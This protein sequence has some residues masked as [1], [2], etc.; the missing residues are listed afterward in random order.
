MTSLAAPPSAPEIKSSPSPGVPTGIMDWMRRKGW[1]GMRPIQAEALRAWRADDHDLLIIAGT[2]S[3]KTEAAWL[4]VA[5]TI[6]DA[7]DEGGVVALGLFPTKALLND[8]AGRLREMLGSADIPVH[9][10]HGDTSQA[11]RSLI[12]RHAGG[13]LLTTPESMEG[14]L[15]HRDNHR[16]LFGRVRAV[17]ID[18]YHMFLGKERGAHLRGLLARIER[19]QRARVR[20]V[21][22]SATLGNPPAAA[23]W[24]RTAQ[25]PATLVVAPRKPPTITC[26]LRTYVAVNAIDSKR[27]RGW[28]GSW[29]DHGD[30]ITGYPSVVMTNLN[31]PSHATLL[32]DL[33]NHH[34]GETTSI[35][36]A[37]SRNRIE[38]LAARLRIMA[39]K[40]GLPDDWALLHH[41]SL[42][43]TRR[44][45]VESQLRDG[46]PH[47][48]LASSTLELGVD[49]GMVRAVACLGSVPS[50][51]SLAQRLGRAGRR[52]GDQPIFR[53]YLSATIPVP[54]AGMGSEQMLQLD[55]VRGLAVLNLW[56]SGWMESPEV[57]HWHLSTAVHQLLSLVTQSGAVMPAEIYATLATPDA[58]PALRAPRLFAQILDSLVRSRHLDMGPDGS[59][60]LGSA[61]AALM[62]GPSAMSAFHTQT[63]YEVY[64]NGESKGT[65]PMSERL[66]ASNGFVLGGETWHIRTIDHDRR[67]IE[68]EAWS[69]TAPPFFLGTAPGIHD[70]IVTE[71]RL[72]LATDMPVPQ[73]AVD[74]QTM[75]ALNLGREAYRQANLAALTITLSSGGT[76]IWAWHGD[77]CLTALGIYFH[78]GGLDA[79]TEMVSLR[80]P[81]AMPQTVVKVARAQGPDVAQV[82]R[83]HLRT[84][85]KASTH[86]FDDLLPT[87]VR[88]EQFIACAL[89]IDAAREVVER[90]IAT[91][92]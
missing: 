11:D 31:R 48:C 92:A 10:W 8:Q 49:I 68:V 47:C 43:R 57:D 26:E 61:G 59:L 20:R 17:V 25:S 89:D 6:T 35:V 19:I 42:D 72:F 33:F 2:A 70:R 77:R 84:T 14:M 32:R 75:E 51:S 16:P 67:I 13:V 58:F 45:R 22:L 34:R 81:H 76:S 28:E 60:T 71:M 80:F 41:G 83:R 52:T 9:I 29:D 53:Q 36:F 85:Q 74:A 54:I 78:A 50:V 86:K 91:S 5:T 63:T 24:L 27:L 15:R 1:S 55:V 65:L 56:R 90:V 39:V 40:A 21:A 23:A 88:I 64:S 38:R 18:E 30:P 4:P 66:A 73:V 12:L 62:H 7:Q 69:G 87:D 3:G 79:T 37:N 82:I 44:E 46:K